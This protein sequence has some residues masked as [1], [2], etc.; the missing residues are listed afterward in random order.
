M[1]GRSI[2][3][4]QQLKML[5]PHR[6]SDCSNDDGD[7]DDDEDDCNDDDGDDEDDSNDDDDD[8]DC[9]DGDD[10]DEDDEGDDDLYRA[11]VVTYF[12]VCSH[13]QLHLAELNHNQE[14]LPNLPLLASLR[15]LQ[16]SSWLHLP[17]PFS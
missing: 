4:G 5:S 13:K 6:S 1:G 11:C 9:N 3:S 12:Q 2:V 17:P 16:L 8:D 7:N 10:D 15:L 14:R